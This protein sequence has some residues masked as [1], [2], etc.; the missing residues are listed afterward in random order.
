[1]EATESPSVT[2]THARLCTYQFQLYVVI[3]K[4]GLN[5]SQ[6]RGQITVGQKKHTTEH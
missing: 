2:E 6:I 3:A 1:M 5:F 4:S